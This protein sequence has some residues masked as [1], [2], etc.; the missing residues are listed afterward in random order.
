MSQFSES[1]SVSYPI[2]AKHAYGSRG[3]GNTLLKSELEVRSMVL[4][5]ILKAMFEKFYNFNKV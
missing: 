2:V 3:T 4:V 5:K 1:D